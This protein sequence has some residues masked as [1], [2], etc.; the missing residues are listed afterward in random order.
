M[1]SLPEEYRYIWEEKLIQIQEHVVEE[2]LLGSPIMGLPI[3]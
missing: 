2:I 1:V 3:L